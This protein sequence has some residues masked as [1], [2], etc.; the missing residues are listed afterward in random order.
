MNLPR[1]RKEQEIWQACDDLLA[2]GKTVRE[3]T[4]EAIAVRLRELRYKAGSSNERY[5]YRD[6]WMAAR[7]LS[8]E[9]QNKNVADISDPISRAATIFRDGIERELRLDYDKKYQQLQATLDDKEALLQLR[10]GQLQ[11]C[12]TERDELKCAYQ[13]LTERYSIEIQ[14]AQRLKYDNFQLQ[15]INTQLKQQVEQA[16]KGAQ[17][18]IQTFEQ[19]LAH[20]Q[21]AQQ[22]QLTQIEA[23]HAAHLSD[24]KEAAENQR[25][26]M[27][28][29]VEDAKALAKRTQQALIQSQDEAM[30]LKQ[31]QH[32][33]QAGFEQMQAQLQQLQAEKQA[34]FHHVIETLNT[35]AGQLEQV[36]ALQAHNQSRLQNLP[37][38]AQ[39]ISE[40]KFNIDA[41]MAGRAGKKRNETTS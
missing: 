15:A 28:M 12:H 7:G 21:Q 19:A 30:A 31:K 32:S 37:T 14:D 24:I 17:Q 40:L 33:L 16:E 29:E 6:S 36:I 25:H 9:E 5:K 4:G 41:L 2:V 26:R 34:S 11:Q 1:T 39:A 10:E 13:E 35:Q 38:L 20:Y 3:I 27:M 23:T 22:T 8:R 18:Q